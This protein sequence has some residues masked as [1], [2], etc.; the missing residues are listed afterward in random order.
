MLYGCDVSSWNTVA[1]EASGAKDFGIVKCTE[2]VNYVNPLY[3]DQVKW[4]RDNGR[5]VG[6]YHFASSVSP[7]LEANYFLANIDLRPGELVFL[8]ME[9]GAA[10]NYR[11]AWANQWMQYVA[12]KLKMD[13]I[14]YVNKSWATILGSA[15]HNLYTFPLWI[16]DYNSPVGSPDIKGWSVWSFQQ[17]TSKPFDLDVFNGDRSTWALLAN[18]HPSV[19][20]KPVVYTQPAIQAPAWPL[21]PKHYFGTLEQTNPFCHSGTYSPG[22]REHIKDYQQRMFNRGW[23]QIGTVDGVFGPKTYAITKLFQTEKRLTIDGKVGPQ[24]WGAA[25]TS[26]V[27]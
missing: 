25:W 15:E 5:L 4:L 14:L 9:S 22:D 3:N 18:V 17:Y 6:H 24:T 13:P 8:D 26:P 1:T 16:A 10:N 23:K 2:N 21:Q 11:A 20:V 19:T 27:T 7:T 12:Q